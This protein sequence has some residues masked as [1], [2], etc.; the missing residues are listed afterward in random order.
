MCPP[1]N[2][3]ESFSPYSPSTF[4]RTFFDVSS[5]Q[6]RYKFDKYRTCI[7]DNTKLYAR[8]FQVATN[9]TNNK[10]IGN[11]CVATECFIPYQLMQKG[12]PKSN[13]RTKMPG[14][15]TLNCL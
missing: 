1:K 2:S 12:M 13:D 6:V 14:I 15:T 4:F 8:N 10:S 7:E 9:L 3:Q 11:L 5:I